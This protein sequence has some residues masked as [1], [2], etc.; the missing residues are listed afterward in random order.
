MT[1]LTNRRCQDDKSVFFYVNVALL[2]EIYGVS[3]L[4]T[5]DVGGLTE[6]CWLSS[7]VVIQR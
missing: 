6:L 1:V 5:Q 2:I 4:M 7:S 3:T